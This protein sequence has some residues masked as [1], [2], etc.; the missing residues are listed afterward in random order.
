MPASAK[1]FLLILAIPLI[2]AISHD[3]YLN[4]FSTQDKINDVTSLNIDAEKFQMTPLG[5]VWMEYSQSTHDMVRDSVSPEQW[6]DIIVPILKTE[7]IYVSL[8]PFA[9]GVVYILF[10][11]MLGIWPFAHLQRF[12]SMSKKQSAPSVYAT[13]KAKKMTY[14]RK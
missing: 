2:L 11:W 3:V 1:S 6:R 7:T 5:W 9:I 12:K 14:G 8:A 4:F 13:D 10:A